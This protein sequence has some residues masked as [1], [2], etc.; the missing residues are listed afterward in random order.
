M[1]KKTSRA[2]GALAQILAIVL[3]PLVLAGLGGWEIVRGQATVAEYRARD[4]MMAVQ[5]G[6]LQALAQRDPKAMITFKGEQQSYAAPL[7]AQMLADGADTLHT[8]LIV[9]RVRLP[10]AWLAACAGLLSLAGG[11]LAVLLVSQAA[12]RSLRSREILV[13]AFSQ[14]RRVVPVALG[15]QVAGVAVALLGVAVFE[16]GGLWFLGSVSTGEVKLV[17]LALVG[18]GGVLWAAFLSLRQLRSTFGLFAPEP[19]RLLGQVVTEAEAPGLFALMRELA[20]DQEAVIPQTVVA[21]AVSGFF[22]TSYPQDLSGQLITGRTLHVCLPQL[23]VLSRAETR[24]VLAHELAHFSGE[25]T[26]YSMHFQPVY[27]GL[28]HGM[29]AV[30]GRPQGRYPAI[31]RMMRPAAALGQYVLDRFDLAVKHW[32]RLREFEADRGALAIES[33]DALATSLLRTAIASDIVDAQLAAMGAHPAEAPT[34]LMRQT[35]EIA[36]AQGFVEPARHLDERQPHPT[37][38]HPPTIQR[39]E[40]AGIVVDDALLARAARKVDPAELADAEALFAD[41]PGVCQAVTAQL[42]ALMVGR[43]Q[44][45]LRQ[46]SQAAAAVGD[47]PVELYERRVS[48][49][50][51]LG[52]LA[53]GCFALAGFLA[54]LL[55][56]GAPTTGDDSDGA[57]RWIAIISA[58]CGA[59]ACY[60]FLRFARRLVPFLVLDAEG[61]RSPAFTGAVP[62]IAVAHITVAGGRGLTT[63]FRLAPDHTLPARTGRLWRFAIRRRSRALVFSGLTPRGMKGQAYLDLLAR[64]RTAAL[65]R[66]EL[67]RRN[68]AG[69]EV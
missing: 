54:W 37:D 3:L 46:V 48:M 68:A 1:P 69:P 60:G 8:E 64:Y 11:V 56:N 41:W 59:A 6:R 34:D 38:T 57:I 7:A 42:R 31:E 43:E 51:V 14:V 16:C 50:V 2:P 12:R 26:A 66:A 23:A 61:F 27:A 49:L 35:L 21:G 4:A 58:V 47:A 39:I 5:A 32:S 63:I 17:M 22:V 53:A 15:C 33:P 10:F 52:V 24:V 29:A 18:A 67:A 40:A 9:A 55:A 36:G 65:A 62:W 19:A 20:H 30:A 44:A 28:L 45:Y 25:D 13:R